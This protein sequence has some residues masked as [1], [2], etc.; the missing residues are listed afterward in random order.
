M[1]S[2]ILDFI[3][4]H[5]FT[6]PTLAKFALGMMIPAILIRWGKK[7]ANHPG[8]LHHVCGIIS[9]PHAMHLTPVK[10]AG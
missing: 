7:P 5:L 9:G 2:H 3:R 10:D 8:L 4:G 6:L 1:Y